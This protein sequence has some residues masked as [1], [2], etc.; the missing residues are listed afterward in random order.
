MPSPP[1]PHLFSSTPPITAEEISKALSKCSNL[2][3]PGPDQIPYGVWKRIHAINPLA[4]PSLLTPLLERGHH[5][6]SLKAA[7]GIV[8]PKPA[9]P[10][11]SD[12]SSFRI[13]VLLETISKLLER[14]V[15]FRLY[16]HAIRHKL[17]HP[18]QGGSLPGRST[19]DAA[20]TLVHEVK[21]LQASGL[22]VSTLFLDIKGGFDNVRAP[23]LAARLRKHNTPDY[24]VNWV[25]SFLSD[26]SCRLLFKG[27]LKQF[28]PVDVG[29]PQGSPIS[30][31]LFVIYVSP[32]HSISIPKGLTLSYVDDFAL[33]KAS[34]SYRSNVRHLQAAWTDLQ[35]IA[36][37]LHITFSIPKTDFIHWRTPYDRNPIQHNPIS[38]NDTLFNP[39]PQVKW[40]GMWFAAALTSHY[41]YQQRLSKATKTFS[42]LKTHSRPGSGL[43]AINARRLAQAVILPTMLYGSTVLQPKASALN[44]LSTLWMKVLRWVTNCFDSSNNNAVYLEVALMPLE[45]YCLKYRLQ[46]AKRICTASP[47]R[48]PLSARLS[49]DFPLSI[50]FR[51]KSSFRHLLAGHPHL[52]RNWN[53]PPKLGRTFLPIDQLA[54]LFK[55]TYLAFEPDGDIGIP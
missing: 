52:P 42:W 34:P 4:I 43:T 14:V 21:L 54:Y 23:V 46:L 9:K 38:L 45:S 33:T 53:Q 44:K 11:Y 8:L 27:G 30:P 18:N 47:H 2:S 32:L 29:V 15:T 5:P 51:T 41:H 19:S 36:N 26:R 35:V 49:Y 12:P 25:L 7:N 16:D 39:L 31:L 24:I 20:T 3:T 55:Q 13:I 22:K 37:K 28:Q 48:N 17:L 50:D 6:L 10:S 40:L 1:L